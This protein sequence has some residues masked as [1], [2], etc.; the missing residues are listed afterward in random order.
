MATMTPTINVDKRGEGLKEE[1]DVETVVVLLNPTDEFVTYSPTVSRDYKTR[2]FKVGV[3]GDGKMRRLGFQ[4]DANRGEFVSVH[5]SH[6]NMEWTREAKRIQK[7]KLTDST[8]T[9]IT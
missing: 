1:E 2:G 8:R 3:D 7:K 5:L 6:V 9:T 4:D